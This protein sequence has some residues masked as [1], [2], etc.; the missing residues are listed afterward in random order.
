MTMTVSDEERREV[1]RLLL[2]VPALRIDEETAIARSRMLPSPC[3][4]CGSRGWIQQGIL[5]GYAPRKSRLS[6]GQTV[7]D[8]NKV[9]E[10]VYVDFGYAG[11][12][13]IYHIASEDMDSCHATFLPPLKKEYGIEVMS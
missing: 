1:R 10:I 9:Y 5:Y 7:T 4:K 11:S 3:P 12:E 2:T 13:E 6:K 8:G